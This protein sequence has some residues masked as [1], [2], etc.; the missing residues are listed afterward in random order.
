MRQ[1]AAI[2]FADIV[3]YTAIMQDSESVAH[4]KRRRFKEVVEESVKTTHGKILQYYGDGT[5]VI[6][7]STINAVNCSIE[8]QKQWR[9]E[10]QVNVRIG[11]HSGDVTVEDETVYGDGV[12]L[13]SRIESL[14]V[15]GGIFISEKVFD[16]VKNHDQIKVSEVGY[17]ELKNIKE[18]VR[19]FAISNHGIVVP[20]RHELSGKT[21]APINRLAVLP[22][23]NMSADPENEFF[24][25]GIT[26]ELL[27]ALTKV[28]GLQVTSRTSAFAFKGKQDDIRDIAVK[29]NVDKI[30]EGSV[31]K[32]GSRVRITAQLINAADGY[33]IW[34]ENYDRNLTD[35]FE[36]QDE[37]SNIIANKLRENL[38]P[39][40][41][42]THLVKA[43]TRNMEAYTLYLQGLHFW[44]KVTPGDVRTAIKC[45]EKAVQL[46]P[47]YAHAYA[48]LANAYTYLGSRGQMKPE[49]AFEFV[50]N[51]SDKALKLDDT[52]AESH[53]AK[54]CA[55]L[56]Y[57]WKWNEAFQPLQ[58]AIRLN[59]GAMDA[60]QVLAWYYMTIGKAQEGVKVLEH[61]VQM[62]PISPN[63]NHALT[64]CYLAVE[65][66]DDVI[67]IADKMIELN[68]QMRAFIE[69]KGWATGM[70]EG[71]DKALE[72][73][74]E[75]H[76]LT[77]DPLKGLSPM[78]YAY[79]K[80]GRVEDAMECINKIEQRGVVEPDTVVHGDLMIAWAG[81]GNKEKTIYHLI[82]AL[83][84]K[85][86]PFYFM[87]MPMM[88]GF[89]SHPEYEKLREK[90]GLSEFYSTETKS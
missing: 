8:M 7:N 10:P 63:I 67:R 33:H 18:P 11:I 89:D 21:K 50:K 26:E 83:E 42:T 58:T 70:K 16:E 66:Y 2:L 36:V 19:I 43:P 51:Y 69:V 64:H 59:P 44:N 3:G 61:A 88:K 49:I 78:A 52:I 55:N 46:E 31:R 32:A 75:V 28:D 62:D 81:I 57:Q 6:F 13:A 80:L 29:L 23:V 68:P 72:L 17:F 9:Q 1:L 54:A 60:Y 37:I 65:R 20:A 27:N 71:W 38:S 24:S 76:R 48:M 14:S 40:E 22:F 73:F 4:E 15:P 90:V 5:L 30:L 86:M 84:K 77:N 34:S 39:A 79:G 47:D 85:M 87:V 41:K 56:F 35:I 45:W 82:K 74:K 12:N 25:D 53:I